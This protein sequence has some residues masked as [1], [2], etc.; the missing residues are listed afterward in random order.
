MFAFS[1]EYDA[2]DTEN[3]KIISVANVLKYG[4]FIRCIIL[5]GWVGLGLSSRA[6][7]FLGNLFPKLKNSLL[8][9]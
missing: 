1:F 9:F 4:V 2:N 6:G 8:A 7:F 5:T 3:S